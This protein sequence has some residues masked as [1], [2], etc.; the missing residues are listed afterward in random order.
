MVELNAPSS[1]AILKTSVRRA[2]AGSDRRTKA[3]HSFWTRWQTGSILALGDALAVLISMSIP[4]MLANPATAGVNVY[5]IDLHLL[6]IFLASCFAA[7]LYGSSVSSPILRFH[8]RLVAIYTSAGATT[9][10]CTV[11]GGDLALLFYLGACVALLLPVS[12]YTEKAITALFIARR[13]RIPGSLAS[14]VE[15]KLPNAFNANAMSG[16][17]MVLGLLPRQDSLPRQASGSRR[18]YL[19]LKRLADYLITIPAALLALPIIAC[20]VAAIRLADPGPAFYRQSRVGR[21][22]AVT[23]ILKLRT[24]YVDAPQRL[25]RE[26]RINSEVRAE[27][28]RFFKLRND[29]RI[30]PGIG[31]F[32]RRTSLDEVPQ[33]WNILRGDMTLVG[34]RPFPAYHVAQFDAEFQK[35]RASV[36]P[37]LTGLWQVHARSNGDLAT[38]NA[39]DL[40]YIENKSIWLDLYI[41]IETVPAVLCAKGAR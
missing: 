21:N 24:M 23:L 11:L 40:F 3:K 2:L 19:F 18:L 16:N 25:E 14:L 1:P 7:G 28:E 31:H 29:P 32:L 13:R 5:T 35:K 4:R 26:L 27:W 9:L 36:T 38:Q 12:T 33:I 22:G 30:L 10:L 34:P 17:D 37:G 41:L 6:P 39:L 8:H 20:L 15:A